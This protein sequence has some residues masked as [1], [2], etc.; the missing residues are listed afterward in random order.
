M[1][2]KTRLILIQFCLVGSFLVLPLLTLAQ[3]TDFITCDGP[4]GI[5]GTKGACTLNSLI[6]KDG[7]INKFMDF[8]IKYIL[9]PI[10]TA[11]ILYSGIKLALPG[12][13]EVRTEMKNLLWTV[14]WGMVLVF[15]AYLIVQSIISGLARP[16][17]PGAAALDIFRK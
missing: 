15:A 12:R 9:I 6:G 1:A 3:Q 8:T 2:S 7:L 4:Q 11:A 13:P 14:V 5:Q 16:S 10:A 17:G